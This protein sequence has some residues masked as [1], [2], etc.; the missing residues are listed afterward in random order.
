MQEEAQELEVIEEQEFV[1]VKDQRL[2]E[3]EKAAATD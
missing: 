2:E 3:V 1:R